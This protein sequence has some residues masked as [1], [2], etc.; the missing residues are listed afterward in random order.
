MKREAMESARVFWLETAH[1]HFHHGQEVRVALLWGEGMKP[2]R[3][4]GAEDLSAH[5]VDPAGSRTEIPLVEAEGGKRLSFTA[6]EEGMYSVTVESLT[7]TARVMVP[8]G[9][10]VSGKGTPLGR[11]LEIAPVESYAFHHQ[12]TAEMQVLMDGGPLPG[13]VVQATYHLYVGPQSYPYQ[14]VTDQRGLFRFTFMEKGHW[15]FLVR[16]GQQFATLVVPGVH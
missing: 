10:H 15:L 16:Y 11:G 7:G 8:V 6:G 9:H 4:C 14:V 3:T 12:E 1:L 2:E 5:V 13:A